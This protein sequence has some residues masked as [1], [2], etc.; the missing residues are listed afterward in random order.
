MHDSG[1][2]PV[3]VPELQPKGHER[4]TMLLVRVLLGSREAIL[5]L[6]APKLSSAWSLPLGP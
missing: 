5:M 3:C 4:N 2:V 1:M 6:V